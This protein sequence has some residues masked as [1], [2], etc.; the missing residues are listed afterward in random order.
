MIPRK[1]KYNPPAICGTAE[2]MLERTLMASNIVE[3]DEMI[4]IEGQQTDGF[5]QD[6]DLDFTW[7]WE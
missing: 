5:Y 7:S 3:V 1:K 4:T 2:V 6:A